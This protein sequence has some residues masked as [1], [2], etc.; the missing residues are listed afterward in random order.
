MYR[1]T[2]PTHRFVMA[3]D[4]REWIKFTITYAQDRKVVLEKTETDNFTVEEFTTRDCHGDEI[5]VYMLSVTL[6]QEETQKFRT[7]AR[8][9]EAQIRCL[10]STGDSFSSQMIPLRVRDVLNNRVLE[11]E[12]GAGINF[13]S[14]SEE[15]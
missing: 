6:S 13:N 8:R 2:T 3:L 14:G 1:L 15:K 7:S 4:P 10:Y 11:C 5:P 9:T 12:E